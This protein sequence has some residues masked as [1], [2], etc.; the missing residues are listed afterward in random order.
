[1]KGAVLPKTNAA[2]ILNPCIGEEALEVWFNVHTVKYATLCLW[3]HCGICLMS[4]WCLLFV[5]LFV[6]V[7]T[8]SKAFFSVQVYKSA[9]DKERSIRN[10]L[11]PQ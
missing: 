4:P 10:S 9:R 7:L 11:A 5:R 3:V 6:L 2:L 1:M 8:S